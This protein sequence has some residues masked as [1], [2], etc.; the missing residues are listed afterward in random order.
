MVH[1]LQR[2]RYEHRQTGLAML[3]LACLP[4]LCLGTLLAL[5]PAADRMLPAPLLPVLCIVTLAVLIGFS[6]LSIQLTADYLVVRFGIG[7]FRKAVA[8]QDVVAAEVVR[9]R[10]YQ[11]WGVH[12]TRRGM[13]YNVAG[14][15]AVRLRLTGGKAMIIGSDEANR[16]AA[17][18]ARALED[19]RGRVAATH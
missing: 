10:W 18:I 11:G 4:A 15:D 1:S 12:W 17:A 2:L 13:L 6:S 16:L 3:G 19:R 7:P 9:T 8:L 14:F 5:T